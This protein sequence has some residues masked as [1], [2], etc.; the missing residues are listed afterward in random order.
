MIP[1]VLTLLLSTLN[2]ASTQAQSN[3]Y[4]QTLSGFALFSNPDPIVF[5]FTGTPEAASDATLALIATSGELAGGFNKRLENLSVEGDIYTTPGI[6]GLTAGYMLPTTQ[7]QEFYTGSSTALPDPVLIP[8]AN[9]NGYVSDGQLVMS[10]DDPPFIAGGNF[11]VT[12]S[13]STTVPE[14]S[15][16]A[17]FAFGLSCAILKRHRKSA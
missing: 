14:P 12:L 3:T 8:L 13:Y 17:L 4:S 16:L 7:T 2:T 11:N 10:V 6:P 15:A 5:T 1:F 9:L